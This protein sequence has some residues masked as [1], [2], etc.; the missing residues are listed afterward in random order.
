VWVLLRWARIGGVGMISDV[1]VQEAGPK[2]KGV[3]ARRDFRKGEFI[4]RRRHGTVISASHVHT[5][6]LEDHA[7]LRTHP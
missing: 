7:P 2:G 1:A 4:F 5:L 3:F 6:P